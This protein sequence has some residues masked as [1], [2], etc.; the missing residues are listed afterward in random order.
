MAMTRSIGVKDF[1]TM[2]N[3]TYTINQDKSLYTKMQ[4]TINLSVQFPLRDLEPLL[5]TNSFCNINSV[6]LMQHSVI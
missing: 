4:L 5:R 3:N 1:I 2:Q 6:V